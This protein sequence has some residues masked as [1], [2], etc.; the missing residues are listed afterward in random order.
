MRNLDFYDCSIEFCRVSS[1]EGTHS[2][3]KITELIGLES[4][5]KDRHVI[6]IEDII[7]TGLTMH[8]LIQCINKLEPASLKVCSLFFKPANSKVDLTPNYIGFTIPPKF[9]LGYGLDIDEQARNIRDIW[10]LKQDLN[11]HISQ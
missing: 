2:T 1:Y 5:I 8:S 6:F 10:V 9:I 11:T 3:G 7:D 4:N